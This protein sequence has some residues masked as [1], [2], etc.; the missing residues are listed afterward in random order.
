M[1]IDRTPVLKRCRSLGISPAVLGLTKKPSNR[2]KDVRPRG[3]KLSEYGMQL[4]EKQKAKFVYGMLEKQFYHLYL[5]AIKMKGV[6]GSNL[7]QL[8]ERRLDNVVFRLAFA[9]TRAEARQLVS[10]GHITVNGKKVDIPSYEVKVDDVIVLREKS[11]S[12]SRITQIQEAT[13]YRLMPSW[14]SLDD[15]RQKGTVTALPTREDID[16]E[17]DERMIIELFSK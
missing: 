14:L 6:A 15:S 3:K 2:F 10:H 17:I 13:S 1:A 5:R 12:S 9:R 4:K 11:R 8:L 16:F 7:L